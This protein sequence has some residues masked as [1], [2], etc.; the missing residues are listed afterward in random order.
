[1]TAIAVRRRSLAVPFGA[2]LALH[3][4]VV[5]ALI[6]AQAGSQTVRPPVYRVSLVAAPAGDRAMGVVNPPKPAATE[7]PP[8]AQAQRPTPRPTQTRTPARQTQR[9]TPTPPRA[10][11]KADRAP[12]QT[13]AKGGPVGGTGTDVANVDLKGLEF[14]FQSYLDNIVRQ[15]ALQFPR[16]WP[17]ALTAEVT[18]MIDA[19]GSIRSP[20]L[21][22]RSGSFE[23]DAEALGAIENVGRRKAFGKLP[24]G[25][26]GDVLPVTFSFD[27]RMF[28]Q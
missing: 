26:A 4:V 11:T 20:R 17:R 14:P 28:G 3:V 7:T 9:A 23:F 15:I 18:F 10:A 13:A 16:E 5:V 21:T 24:D 22:K 27:P 25:Y 19:D 6:I 12:A 1:M 2:S 8:P